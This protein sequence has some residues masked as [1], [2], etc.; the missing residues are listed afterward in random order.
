[1]V[2]N[3][4]DNAAQARVRVPWGD[5]PGESLRLA[6]VLSEAVYDRNS[7]EMTGPGLYIELG[8][9][10]CHFFRCQRSSQSVM[11]RAA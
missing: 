2:V 9:W 6:D 10:M 1:V 5:I 4:S 7:D 11:A 8:P 3:L